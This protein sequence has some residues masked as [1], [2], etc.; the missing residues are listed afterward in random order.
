MSMAT[1]QPDSHLPMPPS[2]HAP[3]ARVLIAGDG[4]AGL[5]ALLA[6]HALAA[7]LLEITILAPELKFINRSMSVD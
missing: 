4:V 6:L 3:R 7:D 2:R 5:E 1:T